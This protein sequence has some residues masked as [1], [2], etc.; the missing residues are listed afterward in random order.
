M[1]TKNRPVAYWVIMIFLI[2]SLILL[3]TGQ[4][5]AIINYD[6]AVQLGLQESVKKVGQYGVQMNR[7]FGASDTI[8]YIPLVALSIAGLA[9]KKHWALLTTAAV[10]GISAYWAT[11]LL[12]MMMLLQGV[13]G[14]TLELSI[15]YWL[16]MLPFII[17]GIWGLIYLVFRGERLIKP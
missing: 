12:I 15:E 8:I 17:F 6:F 11:T 4:T 2:V 14:Y 13:P 9:L 10:M 5:M 16:F 3:L 1:E 7:A